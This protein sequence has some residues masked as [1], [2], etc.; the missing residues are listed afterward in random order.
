MRRHATWWIWPAPILGVSWLTGLL[1]L[2]VPPVFF[3]GLDQQPLDWVL[4]IAAA[5]VLLG[6]LIS[7]VAS[8]LGPAALRTLIPAEQGRWIAGLLGALVCVT[9]TGL[10]WSNFTEN[11]IGMIFWQIFAGAAIDLFVLGWLCLA[12]RAAVSRAPARS[13]LALLSSALTSLVCSY[14]GLAIL[15]EAYFRYGWEPNLAL[16]GLLVVLL[17]GTFLLPPVLAVS[18]MAAIFTSLMSR[19]E[20]GSDN[21]A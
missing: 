7:K 11:V 2:A 10:L 20:G 8:V 12:L 1:L 19:K 9:W 5:V 14:A 21:G 3:R 18:G 15:I 13:G 16:V 4:P 6:Y 17:T